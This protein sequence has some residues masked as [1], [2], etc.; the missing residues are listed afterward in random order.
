MVCPIHLC[1]S[2]EGLRAEGF[3]PPSNRTTLVHWERWVASHCYYNTSSSKSAHNPE[4][5]HG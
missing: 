2:V 1:R 3:P 4:K 5:L